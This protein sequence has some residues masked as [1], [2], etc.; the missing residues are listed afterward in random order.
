MNWI[1]S[2]GTR[3][4]RRRTVQ[5]LAVVI[6]LVMNL[7]LSSCWTWQEGAMPISPEGSGPFSD[8]TI[9]SLHPTFKWE[10]PVSKSETGSNIQ[11]FS[12]EFRLAKCGENSNTWFATGRGRWESGCTPMYEKTGL[13]QPSHQI[14]ITLD[15]GT[16]YCWRVRAMY[17]KDGT[18][19]YSEWSGR[20]GIMLIGVTYTSGQC[21]FFGT[22][23]RQGG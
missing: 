18:P 17:K 11:D 20:S 4:Q 7:S 19:R 12:Y 13:L 15:P 14:E 1:D 16:T 21:N 10:N 2:F 8:P 9:D 6:G 5:A 3:S 22:P 23:P